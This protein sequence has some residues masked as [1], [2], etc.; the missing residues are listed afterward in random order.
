MPCPSQV[1]LRLM[2]QILRLILPDSINS[3]DDIKKRIRMYGPFIRP[4]LVK[5][6][7]FIVFYGFPNLNPNKLLKLVMEYQHVVMI[8]NNR[9]RGLG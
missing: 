8:N 1:Q 6:K 5:C 7:N 9:Q 2:G 4:S 3:D